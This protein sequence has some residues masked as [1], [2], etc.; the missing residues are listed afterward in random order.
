MVSVDFKNVCINN[1]NSKRNIALA[2]AGGA[3]LGGKEVYNTFDNIKFQKTLRDT[4]FR[5][6]KPEE[7]LENSKKKSAEQLKFIE[8]LPPSAKKDELIK[9]LKDFDNKLALKVQNTVNGKNNECNKA[10]K[11]IKKSA[12]FKII[13]KTAGGAAIGM[14]IGLMFS[15]IKNRNK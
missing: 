6:F 12:P 1:Y 5:G 9:N 15:F 10:I 14:G 3:L 8:S 2:V 13:A 4:F 7:L 11:K